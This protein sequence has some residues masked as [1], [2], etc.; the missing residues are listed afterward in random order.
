MKN[1]FSSTAHKNPKEN[2]K[3]INKKLLTHTGDYEDVKKLLVDVLKPCEIS[4]KHL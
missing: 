2:E 1:T 3:D 4:V